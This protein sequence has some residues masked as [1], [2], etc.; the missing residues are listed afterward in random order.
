MF[1][2]EQT[3]QKK[4]LHLHMC[5]WNLEATEGQSSQALGKPSALSFS[6][7]QKNGTK[8]ASTGH[9]V[10]YGKANVIYG[11]RCSQLHK[12]EKRNALYN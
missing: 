12:H 9:E 11:D 2:R 3:A 6:Q 8:P 7:L 10:V 1:K 4:V 5:T